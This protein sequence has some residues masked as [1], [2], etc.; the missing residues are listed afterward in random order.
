MTP[1]WL[2]LLAVAASLPAV[3][4]LARVFFGTPAQL[5]EDLGLAP[6]AVE[7]R[8]QVLRQRIAGHAGE[9]LATIE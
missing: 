9:V 7:W 4:P 8:P 5:A 3:P 6:P 2:I 1:P